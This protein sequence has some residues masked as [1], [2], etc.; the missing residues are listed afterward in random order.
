MGDDR[1]NEAIG[2]NSKQLSGDPASELIHRVRGTKE[3]VSN[4][5]GGSERRGPSPIVDMTP[6]GSKSLIF[7]SVL[8]G[9]HPWLLKGIAPSGQIECTLFMDELRSR[10]PV[11][12]LRLKVESHA[13]RISTGLRHEAALFLGSHMAAAHGIRILKSRRSVMGS[14]FPFPP[15]SSR[16]PP[17]RDYPSRNSPH[18]FR[19]VST[20]G[21]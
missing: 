3:P 8:H 12:P 15:K 16:P 21:P 1:G 7:M 11:S 5:E 4:L 9:F 10:Q 2:L 19:D 20:P 6:S 17:P 14:I 13:H 18:E